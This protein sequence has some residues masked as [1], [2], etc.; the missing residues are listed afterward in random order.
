MTL[1]EKFLELQKEDKNII[2][3][4]TKRERA[5]RLNET[6]RLYTKELTDSHD[7]YLTTKGWTDLHEKWVVKLNLAV[8]IEKAIREFGFEGCLSLEGKCNQEWPVICDF[9]VSGDSKFWSNNSV[10]TL[11]VVQE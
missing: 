1:L 11:K 7:E 8:F 4:V 5:K 9:C 2:G 3:L 6:W 10:S